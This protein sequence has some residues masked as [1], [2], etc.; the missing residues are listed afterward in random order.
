MDNVK[1]ENII[2]EIANIFPVR[3]IADI[4][5]ASAQASYLPPV[6]DD[7][8]KFQNSP[9]DDL[10]DEFRKEIFEISDANKI[11]PVEI[12]KGYEESI[13]RII[14]DEALGNYTYYPKGGFTNKELELSKLFTSVDRDY[15]DLVLSTVAG[16]NFRRSDVYVS[17]ETGIKDPSGLY[18]FDFNKSF[19]DNV[20]LYK[21][22]A[23]R[24]I[25]GFIKTKSL[26]KQFNKTFKI[27]T[28]T[29]YDSL[30]I[31]TPHVMEYLIELDKKYDGKIELSFINHKLYIRVI[32]ENLFANTER[33][34]YLKEE[35]IIEFIEELE[36]VQK[37]ISFL[38]NIN[39]V[40][41]Q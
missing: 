33:N 14:L 26:N 38:K 21:S 24:S 8:S 20:I 27:I 5:E 15:Q 2:T 36:S 39:F 11:S 18:E 13:I 29:K 17:T 16:I 32:G 25:S 6:Y 1:I 34:L 23:G 9:I 12:I 3:R 7:P 4:P 22:I 35:K 19:S 41:E 28:K 40:S 37:L 31:L 30:L 10:A